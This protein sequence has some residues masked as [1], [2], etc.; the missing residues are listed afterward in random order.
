MKLMSAI[1]SLA[2]L[3]VASL[4]YW[5]L[6]TV[7]ATQAQLAQALTTVADRLD[8]AKAEILTTIQELRDAVANTE[9]TTPEV[10][11]LVERLAGQA[12]G[13][14]DIRPDPENPQA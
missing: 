5:R 7:M 4:T 2:T 8:K 14:D 1:I 9:G 10:D 13:L 11:A 12:Q 3:A 6:Q